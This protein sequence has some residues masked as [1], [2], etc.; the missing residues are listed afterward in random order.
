MAFGMAE[1]G[2]RG[3]TADQIAAVF[4][5]PSTGEVLHRAFNA[6]DRELSESGTSTVRLANRLYPRIDFPLRDEFVRTVAAHYGA[7]LERLDFAADPGGSTRKINEWVADRTEERIE[8]LLDPRFID[9]NTVLVL[10]NALYLEAKWAVPFSKEATKPAPFTRLDGSSVD[11]PLMHDP[12]RETRYLDEP[13]LQA[14]EIPYEGGE[15]SMLVLLPAGGMLGELE[16]GLDGDAL[17]AVEAR[18]RP[19]IVDLKLPRWRFGSKIDLLSPLAD[20]GLT[21]LGN[22]GGV[23]TEATP[24][25]DEAV[26]AADIE[27][28]EKGTVAAAATA[29]GFRVCAC[30][31]PRADAVIRADR[32]FLYLIRDTEAGT[33]MFA[34][35]V[36]DPTA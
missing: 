9:A 24:F 12:E 27:V 22:F 7:P 1:A 30:P 23:S 31:P 15:L 33:I 18:M 26:H 4:G 32:P 11:V 20:L 25:L 21:A 35:R 29:L 6:L 8:D 14:V 3:R 13:G 36:V 34:G 5:F 16:R 2:A 17:A 28:A 19:G 10:V